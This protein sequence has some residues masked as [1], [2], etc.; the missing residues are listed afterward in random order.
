MRINKLLA[1]A[2]ALLGALTFCRTVSAGQAPRPESDLWQYLQPEAKLLLGVD[3]RKAKLSPT[4]RMLTREFATQGAQFKASGGAW[5]L[6]D[7]IERVVISTQPRVGDAAE[8]TPPIVVAVEGTIDRSQIKKLMPDG[9][10]IERFKGVDLLVPPPTTKTDLMMAILNDR[11][12]LIGDRDSLMQA[13]EAPQGVKDSALLERARQLS[14]QCEIWAVSTVPPSQTPGIPAPAMKQLEDIEA[15]DFGV[16]LQRGLGLRANLVTK[17]AES[18]KAMATFAQLIASMASQDQKNPE[19]SSLFKNMTVVAEGSEVKINLDIPLAQLERGVVTMKASAQSTGQKTLE[20]LLG[21]GQSG[22]LPP[23]LR[24]A[25]RGYS[26]PA[27]AMSQP[28]EAAPA[29]PAV[30]QKRTIKI[31][32]LDDGDKEINYP[33]GTP[34]N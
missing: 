20:S 23:G 27:V 10:A 4:G 9:T 31:V 33:S 11:V 34:R 19:V 7:Q 18:A 1:A 8:Q 17:T 13:I 30:P 25:A 12:A 24:P 3:W 16:S 14:A 2:A 21:I 32:G 26:Q 6:F 5:A 22:K 28:S 15:L 29:R